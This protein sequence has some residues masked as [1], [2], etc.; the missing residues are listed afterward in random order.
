MISIHLYLKICFWDMI[1]VFPCG[2]AHE[3]WSVAA[4]LVKSTLSTLASFVDWCQFFSVCYQPVS[5]TTE[6]A[7]AESVRQK[8]RGGTQGA[9]PRQ[10]GEGAQRWDS[11]KKSGTGGKVIDVVRQHLHCPSMAICLWRCS[12]IQ[13]MIV[14]SATGLLFGAWKSSLL[15]RVTQ[16]VN[17]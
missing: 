12:C 9:N 11:P 8:R 6:R 15:Q 2:Y 13:V 10:D 4:L 7:S 16:L 3:T 5:C 17:Y 1:S 14:I